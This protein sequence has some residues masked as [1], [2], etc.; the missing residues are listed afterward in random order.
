[1]KYSRE[2]YMNGKCSHR[3]YYGQFVTS[4]TRDIVLRVF[5]LDRIKNSKDEAFNDIPLERWDNL[6]ATHGTM[7]KMKEAGDY[8]SLAGKV[9]IFKEAARQI[10][11]GE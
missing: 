7:E 2:D 5:G 11:D 4:E 9:C 10:R 3:D 8:L 6:I 1:M